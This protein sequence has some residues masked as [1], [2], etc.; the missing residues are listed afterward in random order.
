MFFSS[1][2][3]KSIP[4]FVPPLSMTYPLEG[5]SLEPGRRL[6]RLL[7]HTATLSAQFFKLLLEAAQPLLHHVMFLPR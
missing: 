3:T 5:E 6:G 4:R 1:L 7:L 2:F